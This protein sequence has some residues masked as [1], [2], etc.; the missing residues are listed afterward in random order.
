MKFIGVRILSPEPAETAARLSEKL[1]LPCETAGDD[2]VVGAPG[3]EI[4][5]TKGDIAA[6]QEAQEGYYVGLQHLAFNSTDLPASVKLCLE[7]G[8]EL[9]NGEAISY[10]PK[11][12]GTGMNYVNPVCPDGY[13]L[14][15][16]QR[17]DLPAAPMRGM[18]CGME[19]IGIPVRNLE[20][21]IAWYEKLGFKAGSVVLNHRDSDNADIHCA[22]LEGDGVILETYEFQ[23]MDHEPFANQS[24]HAL[25][26]AGEKDEVLT[27]P[28]GEIIEVT[29]A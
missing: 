2:Y 4:R 5:F 1:Q 14:E 19:H 3:C 13:G 9:T 11:I 10:N 8:T 16:C 7:H 20:E 21:S 17:L 25:R 12:W 15:I 28:N 6:P 23:H 22:M 24:F 18:T 26:F 27:G 29:A